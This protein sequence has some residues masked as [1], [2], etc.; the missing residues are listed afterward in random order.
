[1]REHDEEYRKIIKARSDSLLA[2]LGKVAED[3]MLER[4]DQW[5]KESPD[6]K[7]PAELEAKILDIPRRLDKEKEKKRRK[8][9][10][11]KFAKIAAVVILLVSISFT[12]LVANVDALRLRIFEFLFQSNEEYTKVIPMEKEGNQSDVIDN[13]PVEW[14]SVY[15][16]TYL[17]EGYEL[18]QTEE[19]GDAKIITFENE[20]ADILIFF[21]ESWDGANLYIDNEDVQ[22]GETTINSNPGFWQS[23]GENFTLIW[24]QSNNRFMLEGAL[25]HDEMIKIAEKVSYK[26]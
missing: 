11:K 22:R 2:Y 16:P 4:F 25:A 10:F 17:P 24:M 18:L 7:I 26:K 21:Q 3:E 6:L 5:D 13:L 14:E 9:N 20:G 1:M 15:Y 23:K 12:A 19:L 8:E